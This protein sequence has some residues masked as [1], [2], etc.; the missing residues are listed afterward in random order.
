[1]FGEVMPVNVIRSVRIGDGGEHSPVT[2]AQQV[3]CT[4]SPQSRASGC[5]RYR[6]TSRSPCIARCGWMIAALPAHRHRP[7]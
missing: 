6:E 2:S 7:L 3:G 4:M 1:M 5:T